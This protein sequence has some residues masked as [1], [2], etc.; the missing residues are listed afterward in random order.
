MTSLLPCPFCGSE[1]EF[2]VV[3]TTPTDPDFGGHFIQCTAPDCH[4]CMGL[5]FPCGDD[6]RPALAEA[7][8]SR[9]HST[10]GEI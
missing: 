7:W 8:N 4:G 1:A 5:R 3:N 9:C 2:G 10:Q 6:P